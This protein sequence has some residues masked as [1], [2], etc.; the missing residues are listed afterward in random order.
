LEVGA[1]IGR[2]IAGKNMVLNTLL[3]VLPGGGGEPCPWW[4]AS[5]PCTWC[6]LTVVS[7]LLMAGF[8]V[9]DGGCNLARMLK[10]DW[11]CRRVLAVEQAE[12]RP[13]I[14][15]ADLTR[16]KSSCAAHI[17]LSSV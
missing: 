6:L 4:V 1:A 11:I 3:C 13:L 2:M 5:G 7:L 16:V 8:G 12:A 14:I 15:K 9:L 17:F 10:R